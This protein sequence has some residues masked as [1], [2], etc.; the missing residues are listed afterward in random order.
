VIEIHVVAFRAGHAM[1]AWLAGK[2]RQSAQTR[3]EG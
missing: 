3:G 1:L 2:T